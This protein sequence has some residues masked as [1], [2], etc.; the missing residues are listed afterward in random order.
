MGDDLVPAHRGIGALL[1]A[2]RR[3]LAGRIT[4]G[5][6]LE[7]GLAA[8][9]SGVSESSN[10]NLRK[11]VMP[12]PRNVASECNKRRSDSTQGEH[13]HQAVPPELGTFPQKRVS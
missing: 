11:P 3:A 12:K 4:A 8:I 7:A 13:K 10:V 5:L 6:D 9:F 2:S 1:A